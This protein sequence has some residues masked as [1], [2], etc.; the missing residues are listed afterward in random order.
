MVSSDYIV[1]NNIGVP[2]R[3]SCYRRSCCVGEIV[4]CRRRRRHATTARPEDSAQFSVAAL[5]A[6][7]LTPS[8]TRFYEALDASVVP[9][10]APGV[11]YDE[12]SLCHRTY[13]VTS[14][15][16]PSLSV[17]VTRGVPQCRRQ[18]F[19][20][21]CALMTNRPKFQFTVNQDGCFCRDPPI[22]R[23]RRLSYP[24]RSAPAARRS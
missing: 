22:S 13:D 16:S 7:S 24:L 1:F 17:V 19:R 11:R 20:H 6:S 8:G 4:P 2:V 9:V 15:S 12:R 18:M 14:W 10:A 21:V 3:T 23:C 5:S